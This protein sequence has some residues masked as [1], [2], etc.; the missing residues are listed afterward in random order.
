MM[1]YRKKR[2][3]R[4]PKITMG[5]KFRTKKG[6]YGCYKYVNGRKVSFVTSRSRR[7]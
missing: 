4:K 2:Y 1:A 6:K 7:Y 5:K 3:T